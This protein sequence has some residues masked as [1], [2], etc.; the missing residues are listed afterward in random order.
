MNPGENAR[1]RVASARRGRYGREH[2]RG[3]SGANRKQASL[4]GEG[5][6]EGHGAPLL[7]ERLSRVESKLNG[8]A[9]ELAKLNQFVQIRLGGIAGE[10]S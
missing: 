9:C 1:L 3:H 10:L 6:A 7:L 2:V 8:V 4:D 5:L